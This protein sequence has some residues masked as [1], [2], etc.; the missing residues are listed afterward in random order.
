M[1]H[2]KADITT[3]PNT[4]QFFVTKWLSL[5]L[6]LFAATSS[7]KGSLLPSVVSI[8]I[9]SDLLTASVRSAVLEKKSIFLDKV[10]CH[11]SGALRVLQSISVALFWAEISDFFLAWWSGHC[12]KSPGYHCVHCCLPPPHLSISSLSTWHLSSFSC[13]FSLM[14]LSFSVT[15]SF[16]MALFLFVYHYSVQVIIWVFLPVLAV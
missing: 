7:N 4:A 2:S 16:S 6:S 12:P 5:L 10:L 8:L 11:R 15:M 9:H 1:R 3:L 14:L 13:S